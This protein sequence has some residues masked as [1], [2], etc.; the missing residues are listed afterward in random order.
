[1]WDIGIGVLRGPAPE[2]EAGEEEKRRLG[3]A[4]AH[5]DRVAEPATVFRYFRKAGWL[6]GM[7]DEFLNAVQGIDRKLQ[8]RVLE[9]MGYIST[10]PTEPKGDTVKPLTGE[11][12]GLWR[13]RIGDYRLIYL[14]DEKKRTIFLLVIGPRGDI[15]D[16]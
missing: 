12:K 4:L 1:V 5:Y 2:E 16:D 7:S 10:K 13:Y 6:L 14:P 11:M 9:A 15:Y 8:G 3:E